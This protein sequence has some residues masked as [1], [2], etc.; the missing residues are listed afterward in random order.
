LLKNSYYDRNQL[1]KDSA[2]VVMIGE[3]TPE[4]GLLD[5]L[6]GIVTGYLLAESMS[7]G[8]CVHQC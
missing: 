4:G 1:E 3:N 7:Y 6:K 5:K 2:L 8:F